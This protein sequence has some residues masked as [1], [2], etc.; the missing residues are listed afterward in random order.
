RGSGTIN[1]QTEVSGR[2]APGNSPGTLTFTESVVQLPG[3][4]LQIDI[5]G[6][7]T[8]EGAGNYSRVI[9]TGE[10]NTYTA[11]GTLEPLLRGITGDANND[12]TPEIGTNF[13][14]VEAEGGV[15]GAFDALSQPTDG[16]A[17]GSTF[18][19]FYGENQIMLAV[20]P[21]SYASFGQTANARAAGRALNGLVANGEG[22]DLEMAIMGLNDA[23]LA[24]TFQQLSGEIHADVIAAGMEV[25][26]LG[27]NGVSQRLAMLRAG[28]TA[29]RAD[30]IDLW[31][32]FLGRTGRIDDD[33]NAV[34][35]RLQAGGIAIGADYV[36]M[37]NLRA[38]VGAATVWGD[39]NTRGF[40]N[41]E[42]NSTQMFVYGSWQQEGFFVDA[43]VAHSW[44]RY[45]TDRNVAL[46]AGTE[47]YTSRVR[48]TNWAG[49]VTVGMRH[50]VRGYSVEPSAGIR[51]D[52]ANRRAVTETG[53]AIARLD[54]DGVSSSAA[55]GRVGARVTRSYVTETTVITPE[56]R[57][58]WVHDFQSGKFRTASLQG[59][60]FQIRTPGVGRNAALI[61]VGLNADVSDTVQV[62]ADYDARLRGSE[63][64]HALSAGVRVRF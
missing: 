11:A 56:I 53:A 7:G 26:R 62:Y 35:Y 28:E 25:R 18:R 63:T 57:A 15:L 43:A 42:S 59:E 22:G 48:G 9:V 40:G 34:G 6:T 12:F 14:I 4:T 23:Q 49:D 33:T 39:V 32:E 10:D 31:V 47:L 16:L 24:N 1:G 5:D 19:V 13:I 29:E 61:G 60:D 38:G 51:W 45:E 2:L 30:H 8:G 17:T 3:S 50:D 37:D 27:R 36:F 41:G 46:N 64:A 20:A 44:D 58:F 21:L 54:V 52:E 55:E